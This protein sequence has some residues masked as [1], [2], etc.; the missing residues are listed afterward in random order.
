MKSLFADAGYWIALLN[1]KDQL[2][3]KANMVSSMLG[4]VRILTSEMVL[5]EVLNS[6]A[7]RG[8]I[9]RKT[10][11]KLIKWLQEDPN[12]DIVPQTNIQFKEALRLYHEREDKDRS[13]TD[14]ASI[15]IIQEKG[16]IEAL[17]YDK[18]FA[19]AGITP[20]LREEG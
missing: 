15:L 18:H 12:T 3:V 11:V 9:L 4:P 17:T 5:T 13:L 19:Q 8:A 10:G 16:I 7:D 6:F 2:H 20:L 1:P 14:C